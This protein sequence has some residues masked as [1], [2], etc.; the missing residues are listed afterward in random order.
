MSGNRY[1]LSNI[2]MHSNLLFAIYFGNAQ[3]K[4]NQ[5]EYYNFPHEYNLM[6]EKPFLKLSK[7]LGVT[8]L[9]FLK[10]IHENTGHV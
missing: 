7:M 3:D 4:L 9:V 6:G 2:I 5:N 10:Q 8:S 1:D